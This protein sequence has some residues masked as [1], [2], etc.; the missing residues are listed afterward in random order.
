MGPRATAITFLIGF[1]SVLGNGRT[2]RL[3]AP[4]TEQFVIE[5]HALRHSLAPPSFAS[6]RLW[7]R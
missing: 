4:V 2:T 6:A 5:D 7:A 3:V 1:S